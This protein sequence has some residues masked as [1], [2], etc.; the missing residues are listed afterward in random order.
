MVLPRFFSVCNYVWKNFGNMHIQKNRS[1]AAKAEPLLIHRKIPTRRDCA[2]GSNKANDQICNH[3]NTA[4]DQSVGKL[5]HNVIQVV[6]G[7]THG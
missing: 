6:R 4:A 7:R 2:S 1:G 5:R 3:C